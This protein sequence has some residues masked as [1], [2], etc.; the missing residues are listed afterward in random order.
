MKNKELEIKI[1]KKKVKIEELEA[2]KVEIDNKI[3]KLQTEIEKLNNII[4]QSRFD[5]I[6][7]VVNAKGLSIDEV[8]GAIQKGDLSALQKRMEEHEETKELEK[9]NNEA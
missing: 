1:E 4:Y 9:E 8:L 7:G 2:Q 6:T 3:E 5:E